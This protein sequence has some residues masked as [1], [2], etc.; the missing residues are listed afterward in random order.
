V[1]VVAGDTKVVERRPLRLD[2]RDHDRPRPDRSA[3][4]PLALGASP[5]DRIL[6]SG[7]IGEHGTAIMLARGEFEARR[8]DRVGH[9]AALDGGWTR[10]SRPPAR[11]CTASATRRAAVASVLNELARA[12]GVALVVREAAVPVRR[13]SPAPARSWAST[14]YVAN[15][16]RL[17]AFARRSR[18]PTRSPR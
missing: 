5:G 14:D 3:R 1:R 2:V 16:G 6:V 10:C 13:P 9:A 7:S 12:S 11:R 8:R 17:V 4:R 15:E 18:P